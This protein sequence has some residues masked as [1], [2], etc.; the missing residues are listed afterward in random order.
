MEGDNRGVESACW[1]LLPESGNL[2]HRIQIWRQ[3]TTESQG[4]SSLS[5][6]ARFRES[7]ALPTCSGYRMIRSGEQET[8]VANSS[9]SPDWNSDGYWKGGTGASH[10]VRSTTNM[11]KRVIQQWRRGQR[12]GGYC[13]IKVRRRVGPASNS[14]DLGQTAEPFSLQGNIFIFPP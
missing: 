6:W 11:L 13:W 12:Q 10:S 5:W 4:R 7:T 8:S 1:A 3:P 9:G 2:T 14:L